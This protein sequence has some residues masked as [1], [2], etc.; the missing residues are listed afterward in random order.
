M[1]K[2]RIDL[3]EELMEYQTCLDCFTDDYPILEQFMPNPSVRRILG[4]VQSSSYGS[5][6][7]ILCPNTSTTDDFCLICGILYCDKQDPL[8]FTP[9]GCPSCGFY[10]RSLVPSLFRRLPKKRTVLFSELFQ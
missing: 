8:H 4:H 3:V 5:D 1:F 10:L 9:G 2:T 7:F 6:C